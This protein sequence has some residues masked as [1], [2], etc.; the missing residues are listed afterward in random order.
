MDT[1]GQERFKALTKYFYKDAGIILMFYDSLDKS[2]FERIKENF[3]DIKKINFSNKP[4][5]ALIRGKYDLNV[6]SNEYRDIITDEEVLEFAD[7]NNIIFF[8][9]SNFEKYE[10]GVNKIIAIV[11][12]EYIRRNNLK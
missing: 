5:Y 11:L 6:K 10:N 2:S 9:L 12:K 3:I 8:H 4:I 7:E 1:S